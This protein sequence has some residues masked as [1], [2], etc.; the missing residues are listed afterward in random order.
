M[1]PREMLW[2]EW[3]ITFESAHA[4]PHAK[5]KTQQLYI[6]FAWE[7]EHD[8]FLCKWKGG[9]MKNVLFF[10]TYDVQFPFPAP[11]FTF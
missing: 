1:L 3:D 7:H 6:M 9:N 10:K 8:V 5:Q 11:S 2:D 4:Y